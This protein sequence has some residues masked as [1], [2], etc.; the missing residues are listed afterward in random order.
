VNDA[1]RRELL[2]LKAED[3]RVREALERDGRLLLGYD[4]EL[5]V[6]HRRHAARLR[7]IIAAHGWPTRSL[8]AEDGVEAAWLIAQHDIAEP[9]FQRQSLK[10]LDDACSRGDV[11]AWQPAYLL[12]RIRMFEGW[13]QVYGTQMA[14]DERGGMDVWPIAERRTLNERRRRVGLPSFEERRVPPTPERS[15]DEPRAD[16]ASMDAWARKAGWRNRI[17][18]LATEPA[19]ASAQRE[20]AYRA[21]SLA[22]EGFIHC[23]EPQQLVAVANRRFRNRH[24]L[25]LLH[26]DI[27]K[28][29]SGGRYENLEGGTELFP[30][31]YGPVNRESIIKV[32]PF[33]P[34]PAGDFDHDHLAAVY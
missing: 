23:S 15:P 25:V 3:A 10:L 5:E 24:D 29:T 6:V 4:P 20:G 21:P 28:L 17:L 34:G 26:I 9:S 16:R 13:P 19:W 30:H 8:V 2:D 18:H 1:L 14:P 7:E 11:P 31:V 22:T 27:A 33:Q 32:T 12:D